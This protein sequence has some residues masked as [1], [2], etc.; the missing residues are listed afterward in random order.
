MK[1]KSEHDNYAQQRCAAYIPRKE[2]FDE[3][4]AT[5]TH[6]RAV[7]GHLRVATPGKYLVITGESGSGKSALI[8][9]WMKSKQS[10]SLGILFISSPLSLIFFI[11]IKQQD[12]FSYTSLARRPSQA[13]FL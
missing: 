11:S 13:R 8:A 10:P 5:I 4:D 7:V 9:N 6:E 3:L 12:Q 1:R 2:Y